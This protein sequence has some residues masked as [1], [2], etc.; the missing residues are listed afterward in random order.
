MLVFYF[1]LVERFINQ[2]I[3]NLINQSINQLL[4]WQRQMAKEKEKSKKNFQKT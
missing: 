2:S 1:Q 3:H 4:K